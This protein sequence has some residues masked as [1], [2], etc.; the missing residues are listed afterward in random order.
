[1]RK[2]FLKA[3]TL[4]LVTMLCALYCFACTLP[5]A[6]MELVGEPTFTC[7]YNE[8]T[9]V[10]DIVVEGVAKNSSDV[11]GSYVAVRFWLYDENQHLIEDAGASIDRLPA[12]KYW[13]FSAKTTTHYEVAS[14]QFHEFY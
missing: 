7:V 6:R 12:E 4:L 11:D 14:I 9:K 10:Y 13:H 5:E 1:M 8:E 2:K 3:F